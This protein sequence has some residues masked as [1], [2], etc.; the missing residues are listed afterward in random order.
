MIGAQTSILFIGQSFSKIFKRFSKTGTVRAG[1][2][3]ELR[4]PKFTAKT[5]VT[6]NAEQQELGYEIGNLHQVKRSVRGH[7]RIWDQLKQF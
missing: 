6:T 2:V 3:C 4:P 5:P 7:K 1:T